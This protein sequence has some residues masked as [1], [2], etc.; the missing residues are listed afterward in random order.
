MF[1]CPVVLIGLLI[2]SVNLTVLLLLVSSGMSR[3]SR[4]GQRI[5]AITKN[6]DNIST[7]ISDQGAYSTAWMSRI[8][9][10][11]QIPR[12]YLDK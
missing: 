5:D 6:L 1:S 10:K 7:K 11:L 3:V 4:L 2:V 9:Q 12:Q 8:D